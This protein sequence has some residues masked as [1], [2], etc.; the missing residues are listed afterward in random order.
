MET[1]DSYI[2]RLKD[3]TK[4]LHICGD[5]NS[6]SKTDYEATFMR[7]NRS[8]QAEGVFAQ[9]KV[10]FGFRRFLTRVCENVLGETI[11]LALAHNVFKLHQKIQ[12][13][14][15]ERHLVPLRETA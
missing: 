8:I 4:K 14:T 11:L 1:L 9:I 10:A 7:M 3:Y 15:L 6:F 2:S 13:S 5:R 12:S